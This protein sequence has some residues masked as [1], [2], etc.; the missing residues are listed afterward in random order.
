[1]GS[2]FEADD[3]DVPL[4]EQIVNK[5][6]ASPDFDSGS[7][8]EIDADI[9]AEIE[10]ELAEDMVSIIIPVTSEGQPSPDLSYALYLANDQELVRTTEKLYWLHMQAQWA[11]RSGVKNFFLTNLHA[12]VLHLEDVKLRLSQTRFHSF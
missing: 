12:E 3:I 2:N 9:L 6:I 4:L 5:N 7:D 8:C 10:A 11:E 1:M